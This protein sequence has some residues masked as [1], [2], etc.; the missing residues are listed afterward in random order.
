M[1]ALIAGGRGNVGLGGGSPAVPG[2]SG[3]T[4]VVHAFKR[5]F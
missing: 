5:G 1:R 2:G 3:A 4:V